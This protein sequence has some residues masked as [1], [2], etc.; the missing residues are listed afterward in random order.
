MEKDSRFQISIKGETSEFYIH[1]VEHEPVHED[2][3]T[4]NAEYKQY[5]AFANEN[6]IITFCL[7]NMGDKSIFFDVQ[8]YHGLFLEDSF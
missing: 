8:F 5:S 4:S 2:T 3:R 1:V 6:T 7:G